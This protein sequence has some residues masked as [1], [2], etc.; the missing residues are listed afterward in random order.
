[1]ALLVYRLKSKL[2]DGALLTQPGGIGSDGDTIT[3]FL[4][5]RGNKVAFLGFFGETVGVGVGGGTIT[6]FLGEANLACPGDKDAS[7]TFLAE[8]GTLAVG[9]KVSILSFFTGLDRETDM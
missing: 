7:L 9:G 4:P 6:F 1:M 2:F 8:T 3:F 5:F